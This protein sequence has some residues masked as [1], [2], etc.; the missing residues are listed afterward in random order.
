MKYHFPVEKKKIK[1]TFSVKKKRIN[2]VVSN[3]PKICKIHI[4]FEL[5]IKRAN[6]ER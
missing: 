5:I 2:L 6:A 1:I 4:E 3:N